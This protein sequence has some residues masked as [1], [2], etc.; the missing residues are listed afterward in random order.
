MLRCGQTDHQGGP[1][2]RRRRRCCLRHGPLRLRADPAGR[3]LGVRALRVAPGPDRERHLRRLPRRAGLGAT[4]VGAAGTA[5]ADHRGWRVRRRGRVGRRARPLALDPRGRG[6]AQRK[7]RRL[8]LGSLLRHRD[9]GGA[10]PP[11]AQAAGGDHDRDEP[12]VGR[13]RRAGPARRAHVVATDLGRHRR[14]RSCRRAGEPARRAP[15]EGWWRRQRRSAEV[16]LAPGHGPTP[17]VRRALLRRRHHLLHLR[18]RRGPQRRAGWIGGATAVRPHRR[19]WTGRITHGLD[20]KCGRHDGDRGRQRLGGQLRARP[21]RTRTYVP[22]ADPGLRAAARNG[23][24]GGF[25]TAGHLDGPGGP[26]PARRRIHPGAGGRCA[27]LDRG[28]CGDGRTHPCHS[29]YRQC[30]CSLP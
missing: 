20:D 1:R 11:P 24:H 6:R 26:G 25:V 10:A 30:S 9:Q 14:C 28:A 8:G 15:A 2:G 18:Q 3:A 7:C 22:A 5:G 16:A 29:G 12:G 23:L 21:A 17:R 19:R 13:A 4:V 27:H